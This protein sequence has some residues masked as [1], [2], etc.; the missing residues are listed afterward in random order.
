MSSVLARAPAVNAPVAGIFF[1]AKPP[2]QSQLQQRMKLPPRYFPPILAEIPNARFLRFTSAGDL[3]VSSPREQ[4]V[5]LLQRDA[6]GDGRA[7]G[8]QKLVTGL[9]APHGLEFVDD[10]LYI[11]E[12]GAVKRIRF[13]A[14]ARTVSG[15]VETVLANLPIGGNHWTKTIRLGA[16]GWM[17]LTMGSTCNVCLETEPRR[18]RARFHH[19]SGY[20]T[21]LP[22][23]ATRSASTGVPRTALYATDN[24]RDL[25]GDD[26]PPCELN[27]I[28]QGKFYGWPFLYEQRARPRLRQ[29]GRKPGRDGRSPPTPLVRTSRRWACTSTAEPRSRA[30]SRAGLRGGARLVEPHQEERLQRWCCSSGSPTLDRRVRLPDRVRAEQERESAARRRARWAG[31]RCSVRRLRGRDL[32]SPLPRLG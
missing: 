11:A 13:D 8:V 29:A 12:T 18:D 10:W 23:C 6:D 26:I 21:L 27:Q 3:L 4:T 17:Y 1:G 7:D 28:E 14:A 30:L 25:L 32:P 19:G 5:F 16:D 2:E 15:S 22:G 24:G 20:E 31:R 9:D